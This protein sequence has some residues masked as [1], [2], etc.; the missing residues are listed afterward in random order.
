MANLSLRG[1]EPLL[2]RTR[3]INVVQLSLDGPPHPPLFTAIVDYSSQSTGRF[4]VEGRGS[5]VLSALVDAYEM[6]GKHEHAPVADRR[7]RRAGDDLPRPTPPEPDASPSREGVRRALEAAKEYFAGHMKVTDPLDALK[8]ISVF[9]DMARD[10]SDTARKLREGLGIEP[11][12]APDPL[13]DLELAVRNNA[14]PGTLTADP[15]GFTVSIVLD[16]FGCF[17]VSGTG[18]VGRSAISAICPRLDLAL[19]ALRYLDEGEHVILDEEGQS[20]CRSCDAGG[21]G[22]KSCGDSRVDS[23]PPKRWPAGG[24]PAGRGTAP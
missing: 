1:W 7:L 6:V 12:A 5:S 2:R 10:A 21:G 14:E 8:I 17:D 15:G 13:A 11:K 19:L 20:V 18:D 4:T 22:C 24:L 23:R 9:D 3:G 16:S